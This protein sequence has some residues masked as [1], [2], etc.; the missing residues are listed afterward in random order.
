[1]GLMLDKGVHDVVFEFEPPYVKES[2]WVSLTGLLIYLLLF[3]I[4][5]YNNRKQ[6]Q[7]IIS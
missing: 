6:P 5:F 2:L 1:M 7:Q 4:S 3:A